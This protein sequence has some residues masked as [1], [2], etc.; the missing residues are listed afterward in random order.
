MSLKTSS[1]RGEDNVRKLM[2]GEL[3]E[4][5]I[6]GFWDDK[7]LD[8]TS[9]TT[10]LSIALCD[11]SRGSEIATSVVDN[12]C[13]PQEKASVFEEVHRTSNP[14]H[15]GCQLFVR[16]SE[17][18]FNCEITGIFQPSLYCPACSATIDLLSR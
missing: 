12:L 2:C 8:Q 13:N 4:I 11:N 14:K 5:V 16:L 15:R 1:D 17:T 6:A 10:V 18:I 9:S 3:L 7:G